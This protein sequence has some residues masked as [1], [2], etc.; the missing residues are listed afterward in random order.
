MRPAGLMVTA[1]QFVVLLSWKK[2]QKATGLAPLL[3]QT[4]WPEAVCLAQGRPR[5]PK[6]MGAPLVLPS[7]TVSV[8]P[9]GRNLAYSLLVSGALPTAIGVTSKEREICGSLG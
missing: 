8:E 4:V 2:T 5:G 6:V 3:T 9:G 1:S 7:F